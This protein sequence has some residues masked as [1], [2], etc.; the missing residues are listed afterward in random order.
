MSVIARQ[1]ENNNVTERE[2]I[3]FTFGWSQNYTVNCGSLQFVG[4]QAILNRQI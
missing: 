2:N 3:S 4:D 1:S